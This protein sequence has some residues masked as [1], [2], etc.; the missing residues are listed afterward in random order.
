MTYGGTDDICILVLVETKLRFFPW[1]VL[2]MSSR[3]G[4]RTMWLAGNELSF[5]SYL[6]PKYF[7]HSWLCWTWRVW[8]ALTNITYH[9]FI[10]YLWNGYRLKC[11]AEVDDVPLCQARLRWARHS[12]HG[13][14]AWMCVCVRSEFLVRAITFVCIEGFS[15]NLTY[16]S[17][18]MRHYVAF[19][20]V[21]KG[22]G[23]T[24]KLNVVSYRWTF[25]G[26]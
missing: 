19:R 3:N 7:F 11:F 24:Y 25:S 10:L 6:W 15:N 12:R 13:V 4:Q 16:M 20:P 5:N 18:T 21:L 14:C 23:H 22:Q 1:R 2:S 9:S 26:P 8:R 17:T